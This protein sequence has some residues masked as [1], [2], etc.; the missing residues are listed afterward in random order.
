M[1]TSMEIWEEKNQG[2]YSTAYGE[3]S[4]H[5]Q[6]GATRFKTREAPTC[7]GP[8]PRNQR[9]GGFPTV[10]DWL[11]EWVLRGSLGTPFSA[12]FL[13]WLRSTEGSCRGSHPGTWDRWLR[14]RKDTSAPSATWSVPMGDPPW[15]FVFMFCT[16]KKTAF[17]DM[18]LFEAMTVAYAAGV[19]LFL[20]KHYALILLFLA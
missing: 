17:T 8:M 14:T 3:S 11:T 9:V 13:V 6:L 1:G 7:K 19:I 20:P 5:H 12:L 2:E 15:T 4:H 10:G 16:N 18:V